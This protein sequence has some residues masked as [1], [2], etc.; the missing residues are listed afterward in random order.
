MRRSPPET[1]ERLQVLGRHDMAE[2][3]GSNR[4]RRTAGF[5]RAQV[6]HWIA[7]RRSWCCLQLL[8]SSSERL[9][10]DTRNS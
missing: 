7:L 4:S 3:H 1:A 9:P 5:E 8:R 10:R 6:Q 2:R